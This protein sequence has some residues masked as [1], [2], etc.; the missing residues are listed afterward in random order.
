MTLAKAC[1]IKTPEFWLSDN[2]QMFVMRRFDLTT[3]G[4]CIGMEDMAE[5]FNLPDR[6]YPSLSPLSIFLGPGIVFLCSLLASI[7]P[8]L[9]LF[10]LHPV[11]AMRSV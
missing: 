6:M 2:H 5:R 4:H 9:R 1:H 8:A 11:R 3:K 7:Y 10:F